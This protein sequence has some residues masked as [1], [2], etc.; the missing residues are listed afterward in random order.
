MSKSLIILC[1][2]G[3]AQSTVFQRAEQEFL[4]E[5]VGVVKRGK[6]AKGTQV[7]T[8]SSPDVSLPNPND[9]AGTQTFLTMLLLQLNI[10]PWAS[11]VNWEAELYKEHGYTFL[12]YFLT[13]NF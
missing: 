7:K 8:F 13:G 6:I 11:N 5:L 3:N 4:K 1:S 10:D 9:K 2:N 12:V